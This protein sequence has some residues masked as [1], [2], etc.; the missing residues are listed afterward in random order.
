MKK[1]KYKLKEMSKTASEKD[2]EKEL[3]KPSDGFEVGQVT[4]SKDG[5]SKSTITDIDPITGA[6]KW[7]ISKLPG[8]DKLYQDISE[9]VT[10][11]KLTYTRARDDKMFREFYEDI[12]V[13]RNKI[14]KHLRNEYPDEYG[15]ITRMM[16]SDVEEISTSAGAGAYLTP[17]AF[18]KKGQKPND[19]AYTEL[20]YKVVKESDPGATLG[21]GPKAGPEGVEDNYYIKGFK[22]K[23]VP[24]N[25]QGNY[26]Q[27]GSGLEVKQLFEKN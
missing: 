1:F 20:G 6:V 5:L 21:P 24:K 17:Y 25:K 4:Y 8:F 14:R 22:Y 12:R 15:R 19:K 13:I 26:V 23:L 2:A 10:T 7:E 3:N 16:E 27:K 11:A 9:L 18:R